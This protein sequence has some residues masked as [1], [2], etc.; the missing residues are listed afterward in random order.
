[1]PGER[2]PDKRARAVLFAGANRIARDAPD[3]AADPDTAA[4][5]GLAVRE[6][7][8]TDPEVREENVDPKANRIGYSADCMQFA[9]LEPTTGGIDLS[10][11][12]G[13]ERLPTAKER[14]AAEDHPNAFRRLYGWARIVLRPGD[15]V[16]TLA[17]WVKTARAHAAE[18]KSKQQVSM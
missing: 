2:W 6:L 9:T 10:L 18:T 5:L 13:T 11:W 8:F 16:S 15:D 17:E 7:L 1:M 14:L 12:L 3:S 4:D